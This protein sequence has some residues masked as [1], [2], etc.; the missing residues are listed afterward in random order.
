MSEKIY[1]A[2]IDAMKY[3]ANNSVIG[4]SDKL[5]AACYGVVLLARNLN[6]S[7]TEHE[8]LQDYW[9]QLVFSK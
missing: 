9:M 7:K 2:A 3:L 8:D 6:L 5:S 4:D 1:R